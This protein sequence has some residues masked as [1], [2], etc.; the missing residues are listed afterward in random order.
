MNAYLVLLLCKQSCNF[1][2]AYTFYDNNL[3]SELFLI[4]YGKLWVDIQSVCH[5]IK[6]KHTKILV[7]IQMENY[8]SIKRKQKKQKKQGKYK[9]K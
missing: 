5:F 7:L 6:K 2:M 1:T 4:N 9:E 3:M 8:F